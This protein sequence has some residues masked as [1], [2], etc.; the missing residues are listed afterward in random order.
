MGKVVE[1]DESV[2]LRAFLQT[3]PAATVNATEQDALAF[4]QESAKATRQLRGSSTIAQQLVRKQKALALLRESGKRL[5]SL[6]L[7]SL[8]VKAAADP[9][10]KVKTL[11]QNLIERLLREA[12]EEATKKGFCDTEL[13]KARKDRD[14]RWEDAKKLNVEIAKLEAKNETLV[15][16]LAE[17]NDTITGLSSSLEMGTQMRWFEKEANMMTLKEAKEGL[18]AVTE[19]LVLLKAFYKQAAKAT[20][21]VQASP[22]DEDTSGPGF[23]SAYK[24]KQSASKAIIGLLEVI[25]SDFERTIKVTTETEKTDAADFVKFDRTSKADIGG[26]ETKTELNDEDLATV[27]ATISEKMT[28]LQT[29]M[30]L[31][32]SAL[33]TIEDL[34][35][36]CI[37]TGMTYAERVAAREEEMEALKQALCILDTDGVEPECSS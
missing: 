33:R 26:K 28:D 21:L 8:A 12:T 34:K 18:K 10:A 2:N 19:A 35:P 29:A 23:Y 7:A 1:S 36:M 9:F 11:I 17:L 13:G 15:L 31:L 3:K 16:E 30:D 27:Q 6:V 20:V 25:K 14:Y 24:G 22:V 4:L 5:N 32:D 37:D